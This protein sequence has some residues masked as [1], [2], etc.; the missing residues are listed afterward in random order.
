MKSIDSEFEDL[1]EKASAVVSTQPQSVVPTEVAEPEPIDK[2]EKAP[3][4]DVQASGESSEEECSEQEVSRKKN[5]K[6]RASR[7]RD[8]Q[9]F[10]S[11]EEFEAL[12]PLVRDEVRQFCRTTFTGLL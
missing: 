11:S 7:K 6:G 8:G 5:K 10:I 1:E 4:E 9:D 3:W 12:V 2:E